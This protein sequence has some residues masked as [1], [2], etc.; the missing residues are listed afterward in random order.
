MLMAVK[1][2][3]LENLPCNIVLGLDAWAIHP[4]TL[5]LNG[6][7]LFK[8]FS[9]VGTVKTEPKLKKGEGVT[10]VNGTDKVRNLMLNILLKHSDNIFEWSG[11]YGLFANDFA[12]IPTNGEVTRVPSFPMNKIKC[13]AMQEILDKNI[14]RGIVETSRSAWNAPACLIKKQLGSKETLASK[15]WHV[16]KDYRQLNPTIIDE[17]FVPQCVQELIDIIENDNKYYCSIGLKQGYHHIPLKVCDPE[18]TTFST[19]GL[20]GK[21]QYRYYHMG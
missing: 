18:K 15:R 20:A 8:G 17:V 12:E 11:R 10:F 5:T 14:E 19:S 7:I 21:L 1:L 4:L 3:I 16:V 13:D 9:Q 2:H 6:K